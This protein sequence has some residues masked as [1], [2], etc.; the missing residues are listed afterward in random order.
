MY[1][2]IFCYSIHFASKT[3]KNAKYKKEKK[4]KKKE[5]KKKIDVYV[6]KY[7]KNPGL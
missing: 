1:S 5:K 4:R 7:T 3:N 6:K 2:P